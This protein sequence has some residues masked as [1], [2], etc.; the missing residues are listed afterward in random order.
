MALRIIGNQRE[1]AINW[2][3]PRFPPF[4]GLWDDASALI[5]EK[6][7][8]ILAC[9]LYNHWYPANSVE[10]SIA[11]VEGKNWLTRQFL[12]AAF[13]NPFLSWGMRRITL[14]IPADNAKSIR[15]ATHLGFLQEGCIREGYASAIDMLIFG[16]LRHECR[17]LGRDY[18]KTE[19]T[20]AA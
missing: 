13:G 19:S 18:V 4:P 10:I 12:A 3:I 7:N 2:S 8:D 5:L 6:D 11:A 1:R 15:F 17:F 20:Y 14:R 16:M 9:V